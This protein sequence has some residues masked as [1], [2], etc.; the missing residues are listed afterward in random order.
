VNE[1]LNKLMKYFDKVEIEPLEEDADGMKFVA[2]GWTLGGMYCG[3]GA[4]PE[5]A[6][7]DLEGCPDEV[8]KKLAGIDR[9]YEAGELNLKPL[10]PTPPADA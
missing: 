4:T 6:L 1:L 7:I 9:A 10:L 2:S 8:R 3:Y 5:G